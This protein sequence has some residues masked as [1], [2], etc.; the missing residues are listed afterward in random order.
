MA[1][2][3]PERGGRQ[4]RVML[5]SASGTYPDWL[6]S[7]ATSTEP[8]DGRLNARTWKKVSQTPTKVAMEN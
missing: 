4:Y 3:G 2:A 8:L 7:E 1:P 5:L 6:R